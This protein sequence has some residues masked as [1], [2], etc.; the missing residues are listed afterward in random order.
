M[1]VRPRVVLTV[2]NAWA[3]RYD[4]IGRQAV[5]N[6]PPR[7]RMSP[8]GSSATTCAVTTPLTRSSARRGRPFAPCERVPATP[9]PA[10]R[11]QHPR[12][13]RGEQPC[14]QR[15]PSFAAGSTLDLDASD[16]TI[17]VDTAGGQIVSVEVLDRPQ[18]ATTLQVTGGIESGLAGDNRLDRRDRAT[19]VLR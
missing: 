1:H 5:G 4:V 16:G 15:A 18:L 6:S 8:F 14:F 3:K 10:R 7:T 2:C 9:S 12:D 11:F 19:S 17:R 13:R